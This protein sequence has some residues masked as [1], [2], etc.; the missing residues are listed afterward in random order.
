MSFAPRPRADRDRFLRPAANPAKWPLW[1]SISLFCVPASFLLAS[2]PYLVSVA[3]VAGLAVFILCFVSTEASLYLLIFSMLLSPE[4]GMGGLGGSSAATASRGVTVRAE[5][6]LLVVM[7]FAWLVH[8]A[9]YKELGLVRQTPLN[10]P[11]G[12]YVA[13]CLAATGMGLILGHVQGVTGFF[14]VLKYVEYFVIY[15][16]VANHVHSPAQI[17]RFTAALLLTALVVCLVALAQVPTG[18][19]VSAPFEGEAGEPNTLGGYLLLVG[20]VAAALALET[21]QRWL[22]RLL[23]GLL[24]VMLIP[25]LATLSRGSYLGVPFVWLTLVALHRR[26]RLLLVGLMLVAVAMGVAFVPETVKDRVMYTFTQDTL[27]ERVRVGDV[28]LDTSTSARIESWKRALADALDSPVWGYGVTGYGFLDA[29]YPRVLVETGLLG[30]L[31]FG[32]LVAAVFRE[33]AKARS[34]TRDPFHRGLALG[35]IAGLV[36]LLVHAAGANTFIIVRIMEPFWFVVG[37][38]VSATRLE[39]ARAA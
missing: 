13:A 37:L 36:G 23:T 32:L 24:A 17:R 20:A 21:E 30:L 33:A 22:R 29:Q 28:Y 12:A 4:I 26:R 16:M 6:L 8:M 34:H 2:M 1:A 5:D 35:L 14:Y 31:L 38:V 27:A 25:F 19:R 39:Q 10:R 3:I 18:T 11:I 7:G 9:V 15:F